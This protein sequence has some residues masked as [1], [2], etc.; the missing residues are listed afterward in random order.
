VR[1]MHAEFVKPSNFGHH[2]VDTGSLGV[3]ETVAEVRRRL[4]TGSMSVGGVDTSGQ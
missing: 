2:I 4:R 3:D 1:H